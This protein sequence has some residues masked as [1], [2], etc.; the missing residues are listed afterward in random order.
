M[1]T[2]MITMTTNGRRKGNQSAGIGARNREH[3]PEATQAGA[4]WELILSRS[5][6]FRSLRLT[7]TG[8]FLAGLIRF[9]RAPRVGLEGRLACRLDGALLSCLL[10]SWCASSSRRC[11]WRRGRLHRVNFNKCVCRVRRGGCSSSSLDDL[12]GQLLS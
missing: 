11:L 12:Q 4:N 7:A 2:M 1:T 3:Q 10:S 5:V 9:V 6:R 8:S